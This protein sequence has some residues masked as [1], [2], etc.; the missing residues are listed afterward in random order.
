MHQPN[1]AFD[2]LIF[3]C[4]SLDDAAEFIYEHLGVQPEIGGRH[5]TM[6]TYNKLLKLDDTTYFEIIAIDPEGKKPGRPRWFN[7]DKFRPGSIPQLIT[8]VVR[9][10][11]IQQAVAKSTLQHGAIKSLQR[12]FYE[13]Q[14]AI[15]PDGTMPMQG[16]APTIIQWK[17]DR[18]P[19]HT[20]SDS[21][22]SLLNIE[23]FHPDAD[24][25]IDSLTSIGF[26]GNFS[27]KKIAVNE[28]PVLNATLKC[29]NGLVTLESEITAG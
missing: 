20:L 5:L 13:W 18:H 15:P 7:M 29:P 10:N 23:A 26:K 27:A 11:D 4:Y 14:I 2:H 24:T 3:G 16:I 22:I 8:W 6:G 25:L 28:N 17:N 12:G 9:T 1:T 21:N 19:A